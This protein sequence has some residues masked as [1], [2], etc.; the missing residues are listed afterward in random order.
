[1]EVDVG[2]TEVEMEIEIVK[3][4]NGYGIYNIDIDT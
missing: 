1:M 4:D 2:G 3:N